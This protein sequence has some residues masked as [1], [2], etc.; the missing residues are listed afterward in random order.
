MKLD[1]KFYLDH[2]VIQYIMFEY[3]VYE[4]QLN[5]KPTN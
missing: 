1:I 5:L 2:T 4:F 3:G